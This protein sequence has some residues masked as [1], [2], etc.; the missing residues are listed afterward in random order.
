MPRQ[1]AVTHTFPYTFP[2]VWGAFEGMVDIQDHEPVL[3]IP[4][5]YL[6]PS[7]FYQGE[8]EDFHKFFEAWMNQS[9]TLMPEYTSEELHGAVH[10]DPYFFQQ[11]ST[12]VFQPDG[13]AVTPP[14]HTEPSPGVGTGK[15]STER[16]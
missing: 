11:I 9:T 16:V 5:V 10:N 8:D 2:I 1:I 13:T 4:Y 12:P 6:L 15:T 3:P 14:T 7:F